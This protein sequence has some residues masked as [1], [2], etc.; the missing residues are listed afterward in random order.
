MRGRGILFSERGFAPL[1]YFSPLSFEGEGV[2]GVRLILI[3]AIIILPTTNQ[4]GR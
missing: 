4:K 1:F 3:S 2:R